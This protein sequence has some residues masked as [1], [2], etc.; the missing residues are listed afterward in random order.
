MWNLSFVNVSFCT[1]LMIYASCHLCL[2][3]IHT[4][5]ANYW[6]LQQICWHHWQI[7]PPFFLMTFCATKWLN[8]FCSACKPCPKILNSFDHSL[9]LDIEICAIMSKKVIILLLEFFFP[10]LLHNNL[11][12][13]TIFPRVNDI[14][15]GSSQGWWC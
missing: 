10:F 1:T 2:F 3:H 14:I 15:N 7:I 13:E 5:F 9:W 4:K 6:Q 11:V 12:V 8:Y